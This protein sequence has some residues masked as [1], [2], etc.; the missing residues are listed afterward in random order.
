MEDFMTQRVINLV[1]IQFDYGD[2]LASAVNNG[3]GLACMAETAARTR[4]LHR[5]Q[6]CVKFVSHFQL[7]K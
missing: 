6:G 3:R 1:V 2:V 7:Q 5:A 4:S